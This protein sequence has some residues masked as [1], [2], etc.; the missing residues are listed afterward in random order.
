MP[1]RAHSSGVRCLGSPSAAAPFASSWA[2]GA[3]RRDPRR[4]RWLPAGRRPWMARTRPRGKPGD[5]RLSRPAV[6]NS[7]TQWMPS[8]TFRPRRHATRPRP[9]CATRQT[10]SGIRGPRRG[11]AVLCGIRFLAI[12]CEGAGRPNPGRRRRAGNDPPQRSPARG[13]PAVHRHRRRHDD[14]DIENTGDPRDLRRDS[15][16]AVRAATREPRP[17]PGSHPIG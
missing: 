1:E 5:R 2:H 15:R 14:N 9:G 3:R 8:F 17:F 13:D 7:R 16:C 4:H 12:C 10:R 11:S 6:T